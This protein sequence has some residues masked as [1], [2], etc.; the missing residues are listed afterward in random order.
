MNTF[1]LGLSIGFAYVAPIG[2]Q[3]LFVI[4]S[5]LTQTKARAYLT[6]LIIIFFDITLALACFFGIGAIMQQSK[7][8]EL[9]ILAIGSVVVI[10]IGISL[11]RSKGELDTSKDM[12]MSIPKLILSACI[13]TWFNPQAI[14]DGSMMIGA[15]SAT[16]PP[17]ET[18]IFILGMNISSALW[19]LGL[20]TVITLFSSK[21][22]NK[23]LRI[24]N[25][26]CGLIIVFYGIKL[27]INFI[28][29]ITPII[30]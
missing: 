9:I 2:L 7:W 13:V 30:S 27:L 5:A 21:I 14:I 16:V 10:Y 12:D 22:T 28:T 3:N 4:N 17:D 25:I 23:V 20:T 18:F 15:T 24:I 29:L 8:L 6:A 1:I 19:F 26:I 11:L